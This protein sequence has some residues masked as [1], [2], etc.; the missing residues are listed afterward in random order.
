[1]RRTIGEFLRFAVVGAGGFAIDAAVFMALLSAGVD[2]YLGRALSAIVAV[3]ATWWLHREWTFRPQGRDARSGAYT[4]YLL[5][6]GGGLLV[7]YV[8]FATVL[9]LT[10]ASP[11]DAF[12]ALVA[13]A[14]VALAFNFAGAR[15]L[16]FGRSS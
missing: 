16:V 11:V 6:Q 1:M 5:V 2:P 12:V 3:T 10:S 8:V 9:S 4:T 15:C 14:A 7:N 13:G